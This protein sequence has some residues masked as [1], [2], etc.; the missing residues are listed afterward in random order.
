MAYHSKNGKWAPGP[1][2]LYDREVATEE[3]VKALIATVRLELTSK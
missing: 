1:R 2:D 3:D